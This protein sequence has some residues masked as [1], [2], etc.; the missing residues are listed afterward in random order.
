[1][2]AFTR[3][4][5]LETDDEADKESGDAARQHRFVACGRELRH[6]ILWPLVV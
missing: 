2:F 3:K 1:L 5:L 4:I 6:H